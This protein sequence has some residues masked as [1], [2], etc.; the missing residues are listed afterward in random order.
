[1]IA[2][3]HSGPLTSR[4]TALAVPPSPA[5]G[6][7]SGKTVILTWVACRRKGSIALAAHL[8]F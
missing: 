2:K 1:M 7:A 5:S 6:F 3:T 8:L 4:A